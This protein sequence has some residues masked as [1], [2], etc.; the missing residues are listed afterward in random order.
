MLDWQTVTTSWF[1]RATASLALLV[2]TA[3][4]L[5]PVIDADHAGRLDPEAAR[6]FSAHAIEHPGVHF[7]TNPGLTVGDHCAICH[8]VRSLGQSTIETRTGASVE[9]PVSVRSR[10]AAIHPSVL[11]QGRHAVRGPPARL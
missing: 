3:G 11:C 10:G 6:A 4:L 8:W 1:T 5:A 7:E 9:G 2:F